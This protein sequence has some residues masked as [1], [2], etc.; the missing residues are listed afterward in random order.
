MSSHNTLI[1]KG[2][3]AVV[4]RNSIRKGYASTGGNTIN[5]CKELVQMG[6]K[7]MGDGAYSVVAQHPEDSQ[8]VIKMTLSKSDGYHEYIGW[9]GKIKEI[10]PKEITQHFPKVLETR[11]VVGGG[12]ITV[13]YKMK[14]NKTD[15]YSGSLETAK[16]ILRKLAKERGIC[17]DISGNN[18]MWYNGRAIITDPWA[19]KE[20]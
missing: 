11:R 19:G 20:H 4:R 9:L 13:L 7:L 10:L 5:V 6:Y 17:D 16:D 8:K 3:Q 1:P 18:I 12:R 14:R 15:D 2:L